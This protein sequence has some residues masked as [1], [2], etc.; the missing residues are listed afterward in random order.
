MAELRFNLDDDLSVSDL[1]KVE[2]WTSRLSHSGKLRLQRRG[3]VVGVL[4]SPNA[5]RELTAQNER[6]EEA[7]HLLENER[8]R[9][10]IEEREGGKLLRGKALRDAL[11]RELK[12]AGLI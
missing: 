4:L 8:D 1:R 11:G 6:Y 3:E 5:W 9:N 12:E 2:D 7:L 10:I